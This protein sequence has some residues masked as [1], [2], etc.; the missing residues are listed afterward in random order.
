MWHLLSFDKAPPGEFRYEQP[1]NG[2]AKKFGPSPLAGE[3]ANKISDFRRGNQ[4]PR[5]NPSECLE[6]LETFTVERLGH[7]E[8]WCYNTDKTFAQ[9]MPATGIPG[10]PTC[11]GQNG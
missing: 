8:R 7:S 5:S 10:C 2:K 9:L 11:G 6:D 4:L 1:F 3:L